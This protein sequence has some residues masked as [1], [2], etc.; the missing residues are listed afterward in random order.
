MGKTIGDMYTQLEGE[1]L[2]Q[3]LISKYN[4]S[5]IVAIARIE[6]ADVIRKFVRCEFDI[7][8]ANDRSYN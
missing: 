2:L 1:E 5:L 6:E 7:D 3:M 8:I 4:E